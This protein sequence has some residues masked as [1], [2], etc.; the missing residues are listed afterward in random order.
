MS[1]N[2]M[3]INQ[4]TL[5]IV[6]DHSML[7]NGLKNYLEMNTQWKVTGAFSGIAEC[8]AALRGA[9]TGTE[10]SGEQT[11]P[12][13]IIVDIQLADGESGFSLVKTLKKDF[14]EIKIV[15]YSMYDTWGFILQAKDLGVQGYISKV[16][17]DEEL[18]RCLSVVQAGGTYYE[19]KSE[20]IQS[21]LESIT[22]VLKKQEKVVF[23]MALQGKTNK[24]IAEELF[25]SLH[26]VE[27]YISYL[28]KLA[29][30]KKREELLEKYK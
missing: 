26:T 28:L 17:S 24:Q 11:L 14:P 10:P 20:S 3:N 18:V 12:E 5:F 2:K 19:K 9:G 6:D 8:L 22:S 15:L 29:G 23:E 1:D 25:I 27:N 21:E 30:C 7:K 13:I 4:N 16:A